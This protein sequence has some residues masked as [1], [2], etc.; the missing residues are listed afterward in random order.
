MGAMQDLTGG[1]ASGTAAG[2]LR[3]KSGV[4][5]SLSG[6]RELIRVFGLL[7]IRVP[8]KVARAAVQKIARRM[9][10]MVRQT[11]E[12]EKKFHESAVPFDTGLLRKSIGFRIWSP[13]SA[14]WAVG[15]TIGPRKGFGTLIVRSRKGK[16]KAL[17]KG[18]IA[19]AVQAG[20]AF[21]RAEYADPVKY[22]HL[23][24]RGTKERQTREGAERGKVEARP[25]MGHAYIR[26]R[27]VMGGVLR[28]EIRNGVEREAIKLA[29]ARKPVFYGN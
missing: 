24:E 22:A 23:V 26:S 20:G 5:L 1:Y 21:K 29:R 27:D 3:A 11:M 9:V 2:R 12:T 15:A 25:F 17:T 18:A 16:K 28:T 7:P 14:N 19:K 4:Y 10:W 6:G 8:Q 13:K